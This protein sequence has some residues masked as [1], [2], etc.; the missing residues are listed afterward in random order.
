[1]HRIEQKVENAFLAN[2]PQF[3]EFPNIIKK[4][5]WNFIPSID[6]VDVSVTVDIMTWRKKF[7][8]LFQNPSWV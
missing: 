7:Q 8:K 3:W 6:A 2:F 5:L 4:Q 1:M